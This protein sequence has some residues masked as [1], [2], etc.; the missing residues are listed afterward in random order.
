MIENHSPCFKRV[1]SPSTTL[2]VTKVCRECNGNLIKHGHSAAGKQRYFCKG[3]N[4]TG[5]EHYTYNAYLPHTNTNISNL[6]CEGCGIL[7]ISRLL[8]ISATTVI[9]RI[10]KIAERIQKPVLS[11]HKV[12]EA[13]EVCTYIGSKK[14]EYW[15]ACALQRESKTIVDFRIGKRTNRTLKN[16]IATLLLSQAKRIYT[17]GL[18]NYASIIPSKMHRVTQYGTN[19]IERMNLNVRTH[20]KRLSR[21]SICYSK[22][23]RILQACLKIY[24]WRSETA[25]IGNR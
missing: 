20:L 21:R 15:I 11:H 4:K 18:Q 5:V 6:L 7:S 19:L 14:N 22:S 8:R 9:S 10:L 24:W 3:C 1:G 2:R 23:L 16:L 12:Y 25:I 13:D 17:D